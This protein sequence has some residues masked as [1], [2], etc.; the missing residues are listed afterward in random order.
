MF[1]YGST[2]EVARA[3]RPRTASIA[4]AIAGTLRDRRGVSALQIAIVL[5]PVA[6]V[7]VL[8][9]VV[10][11]TTGAFTSDTSEDIVYGSVVNTRPALDLSGSVLVAS[12]SGSVDEIM[13][14]VV[15]ALGGTVDLS[16]DITV[17]T[18]TDPDQSLTFTGSELSVTLLRGTNSDNLVEMGDL[19][20]IKLTGL[21]E[22]LEPDLRGAM[23][24][25]IELQPAEQGPLHIQRVTPYSLDTVTDLG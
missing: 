21:K 6:V 15:N 12:S 16:P 2:D 4:G 8:F 25:D 7:Y 19:Y 18:Y 17:V 9:L 23:K 24:F 20:K 14:H 13:F 10:S 3:K 5:V 22:K 11:M 1:A